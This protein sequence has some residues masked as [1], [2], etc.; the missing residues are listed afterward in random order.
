MRGESAVLRHPPAPLL[1]ELP[2]QRLPLRR[3]RRHLNDAGQECVSADVPN[4]H[5]RTAHNNYM[6]RRARH[7]PY[8]TARAAC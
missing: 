5:A 8:L 6:A 2:L 3:L 1:I 7:V 4:M